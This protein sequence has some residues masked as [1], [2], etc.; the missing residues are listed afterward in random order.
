MLDA[1]ARLF[2]AQGYEATSMDDI[3]AACGVTKPMLY[4]YFGSKEGL[5]KALVARAGKHVIRAIA[6]LST[7]RDPKARMYKAA[8]AMISFVEKYRDS[9]QLVFSGG[10][11]AQQPASIAVYRNQ[12]LILTTSTLAKFR[13]KEMS[14]ERAMKLVEPYAHVFL[15]A[16]EAGAQWWLGTP[17]VTIPEVKKLAADVI[18]GMSAMVE[19]KFAELARAEHPGPS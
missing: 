10:N 19:G 14:K 2:S 13:P 1:A 11:R 5:H 3:A 6:E 17:G 8:D 7:E 12:L 4:A 18:E 16:A 9:W 15:G